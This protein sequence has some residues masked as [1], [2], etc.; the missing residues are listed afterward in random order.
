MQMNED[1]FV[2]LGPLTCPHRPRIRFL[3]VASQL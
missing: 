2:K 1:G 3:F